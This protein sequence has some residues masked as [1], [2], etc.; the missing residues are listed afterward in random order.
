MS[1]Q[2]LP[3]FE[4]PIQVEGAQVFFPYQ[5][6]GPHLLTPDGLEVAER[7]D[8]AVD[9]QLDVVRGRTPLLPPKP[10]GVLDLRLCARYRM[11]AS[12]RLLRE[13]RPAAMLAPIGFTAGWLRLVAGAELTDLP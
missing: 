13:L 2:G 8:G 7:G 1:L 9:F 10:Y 4:Q 3:D 12:L 5:G 11:E 6:N